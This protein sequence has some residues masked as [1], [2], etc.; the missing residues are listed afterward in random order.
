M[1]S[2]SPEV[3]KAKVVI[4]P[5][6]EADAPVLAQFRYAFRSVLAKTIEPE[7][8]FIERCAPWM[9]ARL[10]PGG[11]W[12]CWLAECDGVPCG[13]VWVE[14]IE[15]IPNPTEEAEQHAYITNVYVSEEHR[16]RGLGSRLLSAALEWIRT[17]DVHA[18]ILWP[19]DR[20]KSLY[21]RNGFSV[22]EDLF[23]MIL[24]DDD[25]G[26]G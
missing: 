5:A 23:E 4:R 13:N 14:L 19:T 22:R 25:V 8:S 26:P 7:S 9:Q 3:N 12:R 16:G 10:R 17:E 20:S 6:S 21:L 11:A 15:K 18:V 1:K 24:A 2:A